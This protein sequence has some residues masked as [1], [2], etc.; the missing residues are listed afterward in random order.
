[1]TEFSAAFVSA[2]SLAVV[3]NTTT[4]LQL[5]TP[6]NIIKNAAEFIPAANMFIVLTLFL[7]YRQIA[8]PLFLNITTHLQLHTPKNIIKNA[9]EFIPAFQKVILLIFPRFRNFVKTVFSW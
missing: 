9:A 4:Q 2:N 6:E 1:M 5:H 7:L 8:L 3:F